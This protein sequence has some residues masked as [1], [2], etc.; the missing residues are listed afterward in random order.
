MIMLYRR[1]IPKIVVEK[2]GSS[3]SFGYRSI[4]TRSFTPFRVVGDPISQI[5]IQQSNLVDEIMLV[6]RCLNEF[7]PNFCELVLSACELLA[8]PLTVGGG[9]TKSSHA[10]MIFDSGADKVVIGRNRN[11]PALLE[12]I[13]S[14]HGVQSLVVSID[15]SEQDL[16]LGLEVFLERELF[17]GYVDFAG[18]ICLNNISR[19]GGSSGVDLRLVDIYRKETR[20]P[21]IVGCGASSVNQI[22]ECFKVG[23]DGV[24]L[25]T[26]LSQ[27][28][29]SIKQIRA[30]LSSIGVHVRTRN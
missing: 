19:D 28:D 14:N 13:V 22:A 23:S 5:R 12:S 26:F 7:E 16:A 29:Q 6:N 21:I 3:T 10:E 8:T 11:D 20:V 2:F 15:Y 24:T 4:L 27:T 25:S 17:M 30:H 9:I 1:I 18:E